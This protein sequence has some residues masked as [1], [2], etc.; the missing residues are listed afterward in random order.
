MHYLESIVAIL[1]ICSIMMRGR[2][3]SCYAALGMAFSEKKNTLF[4]AY[5][6]LKQAII[7]DML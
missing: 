5:I 1:C 7:K 2:C 3:G 6:L 4:S